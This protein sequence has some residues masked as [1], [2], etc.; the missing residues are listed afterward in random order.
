MAMP[1]AMHECRAVVPLSGLQGLQGA[2]VISELNLQQ[3]Q[4]HDI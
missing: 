4:Y 2:L 1:D 3:I